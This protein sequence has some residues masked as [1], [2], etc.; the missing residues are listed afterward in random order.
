MKIE[1]TEH[2]DIIIHGD[3]YKGLTAIDLVNE[4]LEPIRYE[5]EKIRVA[6]DNILS[7]FYHTPKILR[8]NESRRKFFLSRYTDIDML[9]RIQKDY[10][11]KVQSELNDLLE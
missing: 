2:D 1:H 5:L 8:E 10:L 3:T 7:N 9:L 6:N 11:K 4:Y